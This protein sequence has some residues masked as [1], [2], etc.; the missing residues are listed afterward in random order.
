MRIITNRN[1]QCDRIEGVYFSPSKPN[2]R[3]IGWDQLFFV[4]PHLLECQ[5]VED[6]SR[7][8]IVDQGPVCVV[9]SY[10]YAND[11]CIVIWVVETSGIFFREFD[12]RFVA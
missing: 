2:E 11:E 5:V 12:D 6:I 7:A 4:N 1:R 9:V 8:S 3:G 10:P